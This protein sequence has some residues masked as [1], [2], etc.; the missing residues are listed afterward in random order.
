[1]VE[2]T[3][4][5]YEIGAVVVI[6]MTKKQE[7]IFEKNWRIPL[8]TPVIQFPAGLIDKESAEVVARRELLE[9]TGYE[10]SFITTIKF[11]HN[12]YQGI[13]NGG[14]RIP[15]E[16]YD[17]DTYRELEKGTYFVARIDQ[18]KK[19]VL[20]PEEHT[21]WIWCDFEKGYELIKWDIEKRVFRF[22]NMMIVNG[23]IKE[24]KK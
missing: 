13:E 5:P 4:V 21:D 1:M 6:P 11:P 14:E 18:E 17:G 2:R 15:E 8:E 12:F 9:E 23:E 24:N 16:F 3:N 7:L 10:Q 20:N 19:P 22:V